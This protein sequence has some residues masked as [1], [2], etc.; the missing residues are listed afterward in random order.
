MLVDLAFDIVLVEISRGEVD[1]NPVVVKSSDVDR[2]LSLIILGAGFDEDVAVATANV[3]QVVRRLAEFEDDWEFFDAEAR[4]EQTVGHCKVSINMG[5]MDYF[6]I[7]C[8]QNYVV[9][10][11]CHKELTFGELA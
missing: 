7:L 8:D 9:R 4:E 10:L 6:P 11:D 2:M 3:H 5:L 1:A